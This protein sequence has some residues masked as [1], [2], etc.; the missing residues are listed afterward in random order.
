MIAAD[1]EAALDYELAYRETRFPCFHVCFPFRFRRLDSFA[2][3]IRSFRICVMLP[4]AR[5][6]VLCG[7]RRFE[8]LRITRSL[9]CSMNLI[10]SAMFTGP[11]FD[12]GGLVAIFL[13]VF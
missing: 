7:F 13:P 2:I 6:R 3:F 4:L 8:F 11:P 12:W 5:V 1:Y 10:N 9:L